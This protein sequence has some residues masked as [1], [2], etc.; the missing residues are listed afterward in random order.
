MLQG[1]DIHTGVDLGRVMEAS[2]F[3]AERLG[4]PLTSK[5]YQAELAAAPQAAR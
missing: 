2:R 1:M 5:V 3:I 4:R